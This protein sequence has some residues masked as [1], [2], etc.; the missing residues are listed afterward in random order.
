M[1]DG[2][3]T[4]Q[5]GQKSEFKPIFRQSLHD[6]LEYHF[7]FGP[8]TRT[9]RCADTQFQQSANELKKM[10]QMPCQF[11]VRTGFKVELISDH[12]T[13][14]STL[15]PSILVESKN[16]KWVDLKWSTF[17]QTDPIMCKMNCSAHIGASQKTPTW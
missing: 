5:Q 11:R 2:G 12:R 4:N 10:R 3:T 14:Q 7:E 8:S 17:I 1:N 6:F 13:L 16:L 9:L 15:N